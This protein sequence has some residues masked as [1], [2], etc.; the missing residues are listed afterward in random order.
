MSAYISHVLNRTAEESDT[1]PFLSDQFDVNAYANAIL[2]G[3]IYDPEAPASAEGSGTGKSAKGREAEKGD[4]SAELARL[5]YGIV[6][7]SLQRPDGP[8]TSRRT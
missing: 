5:N 3:R 4:T 8:L 6:C 2:A 1:K 7:C